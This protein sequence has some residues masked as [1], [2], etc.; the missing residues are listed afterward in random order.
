VITQVG[1]RERKQAGQ[2]HQEGR[3]ADH[4]AAIVRVLLDLGAETERNRFAAARL[5]SNNGKRALYSLQRDGMA[6]PCEVVKAGG[7]K[8]DGW[9]LTAAG[10]GASDPDAPT[11]FRS[12]FTRFGGSPS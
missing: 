11:D 2:R 4:R 1:A 6:E 12:D 10:R 5:N 9:R 7:R 8:Y 3:E